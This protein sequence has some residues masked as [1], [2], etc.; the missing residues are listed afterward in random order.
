MRAEKEALCIL[1]DNFRPIPFRKGTEEIPIYSVQSL[2]DTLRE[3]AGREPRV[4]ILDRR[5]GPQLFV[6]LAGKWGAVEAYLDPDRNRGWAATPAVPYISEDLWIT[7]EGEPSLF[8]AA[9]A[10]PV[11]D[12]IQLAAYVTEHGELPNNVVWTDFHGERL[13]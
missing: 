10:M 5:N 7:S 3:L 13:Q 4:V 12:V 9:W 1:T 11:D 8:K 6:A 2:V